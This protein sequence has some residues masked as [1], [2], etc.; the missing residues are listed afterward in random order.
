[1][2]GKIDLKYLIASIIVITGILTVAFCITQPE[3]H[4][5]FQINIIEYIIKIN[6]DGSFE[7]TK[8]ITTQTVKEV[9][10]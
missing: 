10:E 5:P 8:S 9:Q 2:I 3:M 1:M 6:A 4:K 7:S